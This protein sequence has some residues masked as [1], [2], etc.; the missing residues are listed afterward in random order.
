[1]DKP[2]SHLRNE[3]VPGTDA[4]RSIVS[5]GS[6]ENDP[7]YVIDGLPLIEYESVE[8]APPVWRR[9]IVRTDDVAPY[10]AV[11]DNVEP[12]EGMGTLYVAAVHT[13]VDDESSHLANVFVPY[14][15]GDHIDSDSDLETLKGE[16]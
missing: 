3:Y 14:T 12:V 7:A 1:M 6:A 13:A 9:F 16:A 5:A 4:A 15:R 2:S 8:D 11:K 10:I